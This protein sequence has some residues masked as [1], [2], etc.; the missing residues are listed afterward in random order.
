MAQRPSSVSFGDNLDDAETTERLTI[1]LNGTSFELDLSLAQAGQLRRAVAPYAAAARRV[2][3]RPPTAADL[4][5]ALAQPGAGGLLRQ[6]LAARFGGHPQRLDASAALAL[7]VSSRTLQRWLRGR[8]D[9]PTVPVRRQVQVL[10]ALQPTPTTRMREALELEQAEDALHRIRLGARRGDLGRWRD[11]GW[12][13]PHRVLV[14]DVGGGLRRAGLS[15]DSASTVT[16]MSRGA[17]VVDHVVVSNRFTGALVRRALLEAVDGWRIEA[18][19][20]LVAK[21]HTQVWLQQAAAPTLRVLA[22]RRFRFRLS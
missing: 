5:G 9:R 1:A 19:P 18:R 16:R 10:T 13:E 11:A 22:G 15:R 7:E 12:L 17:L 14:L 8:P 3:P 4:A 6:A 2:E 20:E 21:G